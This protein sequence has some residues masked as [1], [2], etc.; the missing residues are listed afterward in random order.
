MH[1]F[2]ADFEVERCT[3]KGLPGVFV[4]LDLTKAHANRLL[5]EEMPLQM[6]K[7]EVLTTD[8]TL[9][10]LMDA[11]RAEI[12]GGCQSGRLYAE[13]LSIALLGY[14]GARFSSRWSPNSVV[15]SRSSQRLTPASIRIVR[16]Y[17]HQHLAADLSI[18]ELGK[19]LNLSAFHFARMFKASVG[20]SPHRFILA[21]RVERATLLLGTGLP[22]SDI[23]VIVGFSSQAH[24][25]KVFRELTGIT[26][27]RSRRR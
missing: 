25:T 26:P 7:T 17:I 19:L 15:G 1:V 21:Q 4:A 14:L 27:A 10:T 2:E 12:E 22:L 23:A 9:A 18:T 5:P 3:W 13:G 16:D 8:N 6:L 11:M 20:V 24:F